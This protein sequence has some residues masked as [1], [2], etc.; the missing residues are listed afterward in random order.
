M[1]TAEGEHTAYPRSLS[2]PQGSQPCPHG[3]GCLAIGANI[4]LIPSRG[5]PDNSRKPGR[6]KCISERTAGKPGTC[7]LNAVFFTGLGTHY[8]QSRFPR[9][10]IFKALVDWLQEIVWFGFHCQTPKGWGLHEFSSSEKNFPY[11]PKPSPLLSQKIQWE[12]IWKQ[13]SS[14][15]RLM[16]HSGIRAP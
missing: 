10:Q 12:G 9:I 3:P 7:F 15:L 16:P 5:L 13:L 1:I 11:H 6:P 2:F 8:S 14:I 4:L